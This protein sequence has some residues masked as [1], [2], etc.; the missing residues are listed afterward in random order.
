MSSPNILFKLDK[1]SKTYHPGDKI[2]GNIVVSTRTSLKHEGIDL[3]FDGQI[4]TNKGLS[5]TENF[6]PASGK[7]SIIIGKSIFLSTT[8]KLCT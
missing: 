7:S 3:Y 6:S 2:T 4:S 5:L 1:V 8:N